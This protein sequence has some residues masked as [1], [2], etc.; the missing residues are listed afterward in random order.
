M[1]QKYPQTTYLKDYTSPPFLVDKVDL[2][3]DLGEE[4]STVKARLRFR[5]N[6]DF[7][8]ENSTLV[9]DGQNMKLQKIHLDNMQMNPN[10]YS[11]DE[12]HLKIT[13]VPKKFVLNRDS[14]SSILDSSIGPV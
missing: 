4:W 8:G 11:V 3:I 6:P 2:E 14:I 13:N 9:L 10:Q 7:E 5:C 12:S 1:K